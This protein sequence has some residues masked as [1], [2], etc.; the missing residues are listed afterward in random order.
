MTTIRT[1]THDR[2]GD[3]GKVGD[4]EQRRQKCETRKG[5]VFSEGRKARQGAARNPTAPSPCLASFRPS[6]LSPSLPLP[7]PPPPPRWWTW[8][9][10]AAPRWGACGSATASRPSSTPPPHPPLP[11]S[12]RRR[13]RARREGRR[14]RNAAAVRAVREVREVRAAAA[15]RTWRG[16]SLAWTRRS[17]WPSSQGNCVKQV[18]GGDGRNNQR[19]RQIKGG[20]GV[21]LGVYAVES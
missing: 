6:M 19:I 14:P 5:G 18:S 20:G 17:R 1:T 21:N 3:K 8:R 10:A 7:L 15:A 12:E 16:T 4:A 13:P 9:K 11:R 2:S